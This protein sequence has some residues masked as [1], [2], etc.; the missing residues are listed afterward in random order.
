MSLGQF[1]NAALSAL[2]SKIYNYPP[3]FLVNVFVLL[4][5]N[6]I[7][8]QLFSYETVLAYFWYRSNKTFLAS[9]AVTVTT[10]FSFVTA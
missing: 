1:T 10:P 4:G 3:T 5:P 8:S 6:F 7:D 2:L 9:V